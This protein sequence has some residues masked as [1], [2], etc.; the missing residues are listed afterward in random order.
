VD[1]TERT[2][3]QIP[4][5]FFAG[6]HDFN[7]PSELVA[8]YLE[9]I[10]APAK[11]ITWFEE[12][13]HSP[14]WEEPE[15]FRARLLEVL[16][17]VQ[18]A[19]AGY[20]ILD[21]EAPIRIPFDVHRGD[22]RIVG[23]VGGRPVRMLIDNG[24]LWDDL[25]FFGSPLVDSLGFTFEGDVALGGSGE[26]PAL[27]SKT[28]SGVTL[29]FPGVEFL[30]QKAVVTPYIPGAPNMWEGSEGQISAALFKNFVVGIDFEKMVITLTEP[31]KFRYEG[32]GV[33]LPMTAMPSGMWAI[34]A[35]LDVP[36]QGPLAVDLA[37]DLGNSNPLQIST[38][39]AHGFTF[40]EE[41]IAASLGFG[42]QGEVLG[43]F[44]PVRKVTLGGIT[45]EDVLTGFDEGNEFEEAM[46]GFELLSRFNL[47]FD[48]PHERLIL[49]PNSHFAD[50][51]EF[52]QGRAYLRSV[53]GGGVQVGRVVPRSPAAE[54]GLQEGDLILEVGGV[55]VSG[56][57]LFQ[58]G[59]VLDVQGGSAEFTMERKGWKVSFEVP[60]AR[61]RFIVNSGKF[62]AGESLGGG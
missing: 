34:P 31:G 22:I 43:R 12:S 23:Q 44:G 56:H 3:F 55:D 45:V 41:S 62:V 27:E 14:P 46:V 4:V 35:T 8:G 11:G 42:M 18:E 5:F 7:T 2:E 29:R 36:G 40:P 50:P 17:Q 30:D 13:G 53:S 21:P 52:S 38:G 16:G 47:T 25:L 33:V 28:T 9:A 57:D 20:K 37:L 51:F 10:D 39:G 59:S 48:Y 49:E 60:V 58:L 19:G 6:R 1:F 24:V 54:A 26:G 15:G 32:A 61:A